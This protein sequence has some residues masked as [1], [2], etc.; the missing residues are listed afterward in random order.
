[1]LICCKLTECVLPRLLRGQAAQAE[2][3]E[4]ARTLA[5]EALRKR[6]EEAAAR[7]CVHAHQTPPAQPMSA[8]AACDEPCLAGCRGTRLAG[9]ERVWFDMTG[10]D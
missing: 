8:C 4:A 1:M 5:Q 6:E 9:G 2:R 3:E 7:R 10:L